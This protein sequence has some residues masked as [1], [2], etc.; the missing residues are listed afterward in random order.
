MDSCAVLLKYHHY[1]SAELLMSVRLLLSH[2]QIECTASSCPLELESWA[3]LAKLKLQ[4]MQSDV[5]LLC[6]ER[7]QAGGSTPVQHYCIS[8]DHPLKYLP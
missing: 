6:I 5:G 2:L 7:S 1:S 3:E 8:V 4:R